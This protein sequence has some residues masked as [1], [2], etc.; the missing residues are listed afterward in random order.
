MKRPSSSPASSASTPCRT[1]RTGAGASRSA[2]GRGRL[3][4]RASGAGGAANDEVYDPAIAGDGSRV[5]FA[6]AASNLGAGSHRDRTQVYVR[7]LDA[8]TTLLASRADGARGAAGDDPSSDPSLSGDG[9]YVAFSSTAGNL[10]GGT[11]RTVSRIYVR[12]LARARTIAVSEPAD[13]FALKPSI[14]ADGRRV[15]YTAI[16]AGRSRVVVRDVRGGPAQ[17][18]SGAGGAAADGSSSDASLAADAQRRV[19]IDGH[20]PLRREDR[21]HSRRLR[22]RPADRCH[23]ARQRARAGRREAPPGGRRADRDARRAAP[24]QARRCVGA[25]AAHGR[26]L[27]LRQ[28]VPSRARPPDRAAG[29]RRRADVAAALAAVPPGHVADRAAAGRLAGAVGGRLLRTPETARQVPLRL[30]DPRAG[31]AHDGGRR[32]TGRAHAPRAAA[33]SAGKPASTPC[34]ARRIWT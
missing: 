27:G 19:R 3:A 7:D 24:G 33:L 14:S 10:A 6:T 25:T 17:L 16:R 26:R 4:S 29:A 2:G 22:P 12:D 9:R 8:R 34:R 20:E 31:H 21:R 1:Q 32:L 5:A 30:R 18:A 15:A 11:S 23:T 28:R 13:G